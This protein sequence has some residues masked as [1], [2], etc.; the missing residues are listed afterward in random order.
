M[1]RTLTILMASLAFI[2]ALASYRFLLLGWGPAF[3]E[4]VAI[5]AAGPVTLAVHILSAPVALATGA[6][7]FFPRL[8]ARRPRLHRW[9]GRVYLAA[10]AIGGTSALLLALSPTGRPG[11]SLGFGLLALAWMGSSALAFRHILRRE[12]AAHRRWMIR[13]YALTLAAVSLRLQLPILFIG[14]G[15]ESYGAA[16]VI[17]AWSCWLPNIAIAEWLIHRRPAPVLAV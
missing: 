15:F 16:S 2:V 10:I 5:H 17:V 12:I 1:S 8:R 7:Q 6:L 9:T 3:S 4:V 13:S 11:A 14:F